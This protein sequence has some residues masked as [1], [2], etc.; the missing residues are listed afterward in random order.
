MRNTAADCS[1]VVQNFPVCAK[2]TWNLYVYDIDRNYY[3]CCPPGQYGVLPVSG[4]AGICKPVDQAV[5][6]SLVATPTDQAGGGGAAATTV[7]GIVTQSTSTVTRTSTLAGG[8][9]T[10]V[11]TAVTEEVTAEATEGAESSSSSGSG[12]SSSGS[13]KKS[14]ALSTGAIVGIAI[15]ALFVLAAILLG[16]WWRKRQARQN[17]INPST[18]PEVYVG[19]QGHTGVGS[20]PLYSTTPQPYQSPVPEYKSPAISSGY[21]GSGGGYGPGTPPSQYGNQQMGYAGTP[22]PVGGY[23]PPPVEAPAP[24]RWNERAEMGTGR[25]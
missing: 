18:M 16:I 20:A 11:T 2:S 9:V 25:T 24:L 17:M 15:G 3:F 21:V 14:S 19:G 12:S 5:A 8:S 4:N 10:V 23:G 1:N 13:K 22:P 7:S 6:S